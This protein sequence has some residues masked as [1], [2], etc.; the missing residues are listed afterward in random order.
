MYNRVRGLRTSG[1]LFLFWFLLALCG[2]VRYH[3]ELT[4]VNSKQVTAYSEY[5]I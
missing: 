4:V 5:H 1:L 3:Y 2:T